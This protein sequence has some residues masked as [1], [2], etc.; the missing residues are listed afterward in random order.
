MRLNCR[1]VCI[2]IEFFPDGRRGVCRLN[3]NMSLQTNH[4]FKIR[5]VARFHF[6]IDAARKMQIR[7]IFPIRRRRCIIKVWLGRPSNSL[8]PLRYILTNTP[9]HQIV[10]IRWRG[11]GLPPVQW[12]AAKRFSPGNREK[13]Q[14]SITDLPHPN[15][16]TAVW[17]ALYPFHRSAAPDTRVIPL[18]FYTTATSLSC[19]RNCC[20]QCFPLK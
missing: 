2:M 13:K 8:R 17:K 16:P 6:A 1:F 9:G 11:I 10:S 5:L 18:E 12:Q 20:G 7:C 4:K 3:G 15:N 19:I 14:T